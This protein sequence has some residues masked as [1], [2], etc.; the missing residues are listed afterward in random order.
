MSPR[1]APPAAASGATAAERLTGL[2]ASP[3]CASGPVRLVLTQR[4]FHKLQPGDVLVCPATAPAWTPLFRLASAVVTD[5]GG[6]LSHAAIVARELGIPAVLGTGRATTAAHDGQ[7]VL[8]DG[9]AG[10]VVLHARS[11]M[12]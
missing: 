9:T 4:E 11:R 6:P 12:A 2:A 1:A 3:G 7:T 5:V 10:V 8:V